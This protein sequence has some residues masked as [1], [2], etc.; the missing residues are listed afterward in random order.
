MSN[1]ALKDANVFAREDTGELIHDSAR[2]S[3]PEKGR[4]IWNT[5]Y[6]KR[7]Y[8]TGTPVKDINPQ[9]RIAV[10]AQRLRLEQA[11]VFADARQNHEA[12]G[13]IWRFTQKSAS[14]CGLV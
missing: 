7:M 3:E 12:G 14:I 13:V 11:E 8:Y 1:E 9:S 5:P 6:A 10:G 4:L 2:S